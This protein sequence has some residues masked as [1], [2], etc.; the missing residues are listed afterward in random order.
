MVEVEG[1]RMLILWM[2]RGQLPRH[3]RQP[4]DRLVDLFPCCSRYLCLPLCSWDSRVMGKVT[5]NLWRQ[6]SL[7]QLCHILCSSTQFTNFC[8]SFSTC[9]WCN[10]Y[11]PPLD[12]VKISMCWQSTS[13]I[14]TDTKHLTLLSSWMHCCREARLPE[15]GTKW[16]SWTDRLV[17]PYL[18]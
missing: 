3:L 8:L 14:K 1:V 4:Q 7:S 9:T 15:N 5:R 2:L 17:P 18:A 16:E 10:T 6:P 12:V 13:E 11:L